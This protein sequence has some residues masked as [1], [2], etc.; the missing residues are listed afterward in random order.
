MYSTLSYTY[1]HLTEIKHNWCT[2][3][4]MSILNPCCLSSTVP[5]DVL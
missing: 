4:D 2:R 1:V 3:I 5:D